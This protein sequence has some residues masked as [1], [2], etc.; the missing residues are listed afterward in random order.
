MVTQ[1]LV[2]ISRTRERSGSSNPLHKEPA[3]CL[4]TLLQGIFAIS[5]ILLPC[6]ALGE[7]NL[8]S[9]RLEVNPRSGTVDDAFNFTVTVEGEGADGVP[10]LLGGEEFKL[11]LL[12]SDVE[13]VGGAHGQRYRMNYRYQLIPKKAGALITPGAELVAGGKRISQSGIL[14]TVETSRLPSGQ[15]TDD[16]FVLQSMDRQQLYVG[17]QAISSLELYST[18]DLY[19]PQFSDLTFDDFWAESLQAEEPFERNVEGTRYWVLRSRRA[20]FPLKDGTITLPSR[21]VK[22]GVITQKVV[23]YPGLGG[24]FNLQTIERV[25]VERELHSNQIP[26]TVRPLP[27]APPGY[28][29][30]GLVT[31]VVGATAFSGSLDRNSVRTGETATLTVKLLST[32]NISGIREIPLSNRSDLRVYQDTPESQ[33]QERAGQA[34]FMKTFKLSIVPLSPGVHKIPEIVLDYFDPRAKSYRRAELKDLQLVAS[35]NALMRES[36]SGASSSTQQAISSSAPMK[37]L[38][39]ELPE[40]GLLHS[41]LNA[42][43][44][45]SL[46][47]ALLGLA[48]LGGVT[49]LLLKPR[50]EEV[51][52]AGTSDEAQEEFLSL[53]RERCGLSPSSGFEALRAGIRRS[54]LEE[55]LAFELLEVVDKLER[56]RGRPHEALIKHI[57]A[58]IPPLRSS[59]K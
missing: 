33:L 16:V 39:P 15:K 4:A 2:R 53:L 6:L 24:L 46:L 7:S 51:V 22:V 14:V 58:L 54:V 59:R 34:V 5:L 23:R 57:E 37:E 3:L 30:W 31:P 26:I 40:E 13:V 29:N 25:P 56:A 32:G 17:E 9:L 19:R 28:K 38:A 48:I 12:G 44:T 18:K 42:V 8:P 41:A 36:S 10:S 47:M 1:R 45:G 43:S 21:T 55:A 27:P 20:I 49:F 50:G 35:G 11:S 52:W